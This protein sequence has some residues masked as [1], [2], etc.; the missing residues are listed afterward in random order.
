MAKVFDRSALPPWAPHFYHR[1][2]GFEPLKPFWGPK[3]LRCSEWPT[4]LDWQRWQQAV[5]PL[6][7]QFTAFDSAKDYET[8]LYHHHEIMV[9]AENWHDFFNNLSWCVFPRLKTAL[10]KAMRLAKGDAQ[11]VRSPAQNVLAH[12][13]ECGM[14]VCA[15]QEDC[16][17]WLAQGHW[18]RFFLSPDIVSRCMPVI[19][20][21]G[22]YEKALKPYVG[23]TG[24]ALLCIVP[25]MFFDYAMQDKL[26][27]L[28]EHIAI[29]ITET[30]FIHSPKELQP[31][32]LLGWPQW[33]PHNSDPVYYDNT[34]YF[35]AQPK[36]SVPL[37]HL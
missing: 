4:V 20:G 34:Q 19:F 26:T 21:H 23:L 7:Y 15:T 9:R 24:K 30:D 22:L 29:K 13:D 8:H 10:F 17:T 6:K 32:P 14:I 31:F 3:A 25:E 33:D 27:F 18:K 5:L 1:F 35:R 28:D 37:I 16:L 36:R 12:F 2:L 11:G